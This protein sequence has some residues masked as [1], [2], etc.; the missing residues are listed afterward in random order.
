MGKYIKAFETHTDYTAFTQTEDFIRPNV[1]YCETQNEVH[2]N[3]IL[4][5]NRLFITYNVEDASNPTKLYYYFNENNLG[6]TGINLFDKI[7]IDGVEVT[8]S[9]I[10]ADEGYYDLTAGEHTVA[11]TLKD[12]TI[13]GNTRINNEFIYRASFDGC[14]AITSVII[15]D[16]IVVIGESTFS[17][18]S[19]LA[20]ITLGNGVERIE[21]EWYE[22]SSLTTITLPSSVTY[23]AGGFYGCTS[24]T[25]IVIT[26]TLVT[27]PDCAFGSDGHWEA[28]NLDQTSKDTILS[29]NPD[30]I[31]TTA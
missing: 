4:P 18:C 20:S 30:V 22:C 8:I 26:N 23:F 13:T 27:I 15:P 11:Y 5:D 17:S 25:S 19:N 29:I 12:P 16:S 6:F 1:S 14:T 2:Y 31:C 10:D 24:L 9:D 28:S 7:E 3:P 21:E